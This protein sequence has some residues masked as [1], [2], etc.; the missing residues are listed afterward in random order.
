MP[1]APKRTLAEFRPES[2]H[3]VG[4]TGRYLAS[5][6]CHDCGTEWEATTARRSNDVGGCPSER[7]IR[8][9]RLQGEQPV[10]VTQPEVV[11]LWR[12]ICSRLRSTCCTAA[13]VVPPSMINR[14]GSTRRRQTASVVGNECSAFV[15][16]Q[17]RGAALDADDPT[18]RDG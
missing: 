17:H 16:D 15:A 10:S 12:T 4:V 18:R 13:A 7:F 11:K 2:P 5:W 6:I 8:I 14:L 3:E 1:G 9:R